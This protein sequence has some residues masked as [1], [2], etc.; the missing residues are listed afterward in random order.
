MGK[1]VLINMPFAALNSPSIALTQLKSMLEDRHKSRMSVEI[2]YLNHDF[3]KYIGIELYQHLVESLDANNSGIGDWFFRQSAFPE[4]ADNADLYFRRYYPYRDEPT[5]ALKRSILQKRPGIDRFLVGLIDRYKI[6]QAEIVGFTSMFSQNAACFA[7]AR[8]LKARNPGVVIVMGGANCEAPMGQ[9]I[10]K[11]VNAI[12]FVF[13][14][15]A[16]KNFPEFVQYCFEDQTEKCNSIGGVFSKLNCSSAG[17]GGIGAIGEDLD[18]DVN[19][20]LDYRGFLDTLKEN[21][22]DQGIK[23]VLF[24]ETSRGCWWGEKAHC[25]FCG[26]NGM[27][28]KYRAMAPERA[29]AQFKSLFSRYACVCSHFECVDNIMP[30]NYLKEVFPFLSVPPHASIFY[31]VKAELSDQ[32]LQVLAQARVKDIQPGI[33]SLAT[34]TLRLMK[35]GTMVFQNL[36]LLKS[37]VAHDIFP[38]WNLLVGFP[39]EGQEVYEKYLHDIPLL[40]HLRPPF[41]V[42]PVRF[43]RYSPYFVKAEQYGLD[44]HPYDFYSLIYPF[45][46]EA[47]ANMAY[48]FMDYNS[49][50][51]YF[52][53]MLEWIGQLRE[54]VELWRNRWYG[55]NQPVP[56]E[57]VFKQR[58]GS[59]VVYDS[60]FGQAIEHEISDGA[61]QMLE[62]LTKPATAVD[63]ASALGE[64]P[65]LDVERNLTFLQERSLIFQEGER[66]LSLVLPR[67]TRTVRRSRDQFYL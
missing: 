32:D 40:T 12:D 26:L 42:Y 64:A 62:R 50:A 17:S 27:T 63:L 30:R 45:N 4:L 34:S 43:D 28:M 20:E 25:T 67:G 24:F 15:P 16:L 9:E 36:I 52:N 49:N 54:K 8:H 10:V 18:I 13:S 31:E 22:P 60:R 44:L 61:R 29:I 38:R 7:F 2:L 3:A 46:E 23:P 58:D 65:G 51:E 48:Y 33:E 57:L 39:G 59:V 19:V 66:F 6:D 5:Q 47:L 14:G 41:G 35:K 21:F 11:H 1:I 56:P 55:E 53:V 37:C